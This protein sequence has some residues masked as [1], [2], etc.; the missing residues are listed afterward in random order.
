MARKFTNIS[1]YTTSYLQCSKLNVKHNNG[2]VTAGGLFYHGNGTV[3][4]SKGLRAV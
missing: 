4:S 1:K 2:I 3:V